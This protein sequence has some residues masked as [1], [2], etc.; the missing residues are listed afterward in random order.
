[1]YYN[2]LNNFVRNKYFNTIKLLK[3]GAHVIRCQGVDWHFL[4]KSLKSQGRFLLV[5]ED[6]CV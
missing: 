5:L 2:N 4:N 3:N 6:E 1:M